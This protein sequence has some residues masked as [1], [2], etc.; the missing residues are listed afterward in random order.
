MITIND[1]TKCNILC[2]CHCLYK[3]CLNCN[4]LNTKCL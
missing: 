2:A 1:I 3:Y 4:H